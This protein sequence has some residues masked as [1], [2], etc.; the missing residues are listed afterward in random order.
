ME[1]QVIIPEAAA[2]EIKNMQE[3]GV[4]VLGYVPTLGGEKYVYHRIADANVPAVVPGKRQVP[5][6]D[7]KLELILSERILVLQRYGRRVYSGI[8]LDAYCIW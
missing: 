1:V 4:T 2:S 8:F 6:S 7:A 3:A 5:R